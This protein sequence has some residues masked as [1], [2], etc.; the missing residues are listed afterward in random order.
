MNY[1]KLIVSLLL[2]LGLCITGTTQAFVGSLMVGLGEM[3]PDVGRIE[4][5]FVA[6]ANMETEEMKGVVHV[7][8]KPGKV[9]DDMVMEGQKIS[10]IRRFDLNRFW[11]LMG[12]GMYMEVDPAKGSRQAPGYKLISR[13]R[14]GREKVNGI[15]TTKYKSVY[16]TEDGR[17]GGFT[18]YTDDNIA[19]KAF[20]VHK[21]R[22][23]KQRFKFEVT[24]LERVSSPDSMFE[25]PAGY[26]KFDLGGMGVMGRGPGGRM[27]PQGGTAWGYPGNPAPPPGSK[28]GRPEEEEGFAEEMAA[29]AQ[30]TAKETVKNE[31]MREIRD[32]I[33]EGMRSLFGR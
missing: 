4:K 11:M 19:I 17:F 13:E 25:I 15:P 12:H 32:S 10:M 20:M 5:P 23:E 9:R 22:G 3:N 1:R 27:A 8:Y 16:Q 33:R 26:R 29:E 30:R 6:D 21:S 7:Y 31:S 18:W 24:R 28:E 2:F 14:V